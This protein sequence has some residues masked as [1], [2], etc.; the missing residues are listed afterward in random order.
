MKLTMNLARGLLGALLLAVCSPAALTQAATPAVGA[1]APDFTLPDQDGK[2]HALKDFRGQWIVLYF[3]PKDG[4]P[5]CTKEA[6]EFR[7]NIF[8]YR[9]L[10]AVVLGVSVDS[11]SSHKS[12]AEKHHLPFTLL[13][14]PAIKATT[15][16]GLV[17]GFAGLR[18]ARRDTFIIDP[19][20][21]I[22]KH[23]ENVSPAG[24][25][26]AV[27]ADLKALVAAARN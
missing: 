15:S 9:Q 20:G 21:R 17:W 12:F 22:A 3:Y 7:D 19:R 18:L 8:G 6:C 24:H 10:G 1:E 25:P 14:D 4:T 26:A 23:Y 2:Q 16:Y 27:L 13:A 5:G 11:D